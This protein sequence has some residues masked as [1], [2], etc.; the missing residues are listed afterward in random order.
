[1]SLSNLNARETVTAYQLL[2]EIA[3]GLKTLAANPKVLKEQIELAYSLP[4]ELQAKSDEARKQIDANQKLV[5]EQKKDLAEINDKL[6]IID[7]Q[8]KSVDKILADIDT[9]NIEL[10]KRKRLLEQGE[11]DLHSSQKE[12]ATDRATLEAE[13]TANLEFRTSLNDREKAISLI[14]AD[15]KQRAEQIGAIAGRK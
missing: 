13:K 11:S 9:R 6:I 8:R 1:M 12:L 7:E 4:A 5:S 14:E 3:D 15:L 10:E 2:L